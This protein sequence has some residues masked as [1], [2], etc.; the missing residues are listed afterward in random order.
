MTH[1]FDIPWPIENLPGVSIYSPK[2]DW[3][4][5]FYK[6]ESICKCGCDKYYDS[7]MKMTADDSP[8]QL[9]EKK[10]HRCEKCHEVRLEHLKEKK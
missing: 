5:K 3:Y 10:V 9:T 1:W 8:I 4:S 6:P 2:V 7:T